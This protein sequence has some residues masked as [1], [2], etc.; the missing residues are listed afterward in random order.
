MAARFDHVLNVWDKMSGNSRKIGFNNSVYLSE[1][2]TGDRNYAIGY[3]MRE[4]KA[5]PEKTNL[6]NTLE[7]YFQCC[8]IEMSTDTL[9]TVAATLANAGMCPLTQEQILHPSTVKNCLSLMN[10]CGMYDFSGEFAFTIGLPAKSGVGGG[11]MLVVPNLMGIA[12][13]SPRLDKLGN[14]VRGLEFCK[15]LIAKYSF[16]K[17]DSLLSTISQKK[18]PRLKRNQSR[19]DG[20][21]S[22]C[23]AATEGDLFEVQHLYAR[24]VDINAADYDG[25]TALHLAASEGRSN[26][27]EFLLNKNVHLNPRDRWGNTPLGDAYRG[28]H[29]GVVRLLEGKGGMR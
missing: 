13:W 25:R 8:S 4:N 1:R 20:I 2:E 16:H 18:D 10:S 7:F 24:G 23:W 17:Y 21:L 9:A 28:K 11:I 19:I 15:E 26:V 5:F 14:S 3:F 27:V 6:I 12:I 22:L 29:E